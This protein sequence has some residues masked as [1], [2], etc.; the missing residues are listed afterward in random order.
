MF[1]LLAWYT[2]QFLQR[3]C[4]LFFDILRSK[5]SL[6]S[7]LHPVIYELL[8]RSKAPFEVPKKQT[9]V[10]DYLRTD[11]SYFPNLPIFRS[12]GPY[13]ADTGKRAKICTKRGGSHP[14]L[15]PGIF[16]LFCSHGM[17]QYSTVISST[18]VMNGM[19]NVCYSCRYL[20]WISG[21]AHS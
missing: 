21:D 2:L 18:T 20:L 10:E 19:P 13:V 4:P 15:L 14:T 12:R 16:T 5:K 17:V 6:P 11:D 3:E 8:K 1:A 7:H 9:S